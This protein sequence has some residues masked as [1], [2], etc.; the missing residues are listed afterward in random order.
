MTV[1]RA[2]KVKCSKERRFP[3]LLYPNSPLTVP[4]CVAP[5]PPEEENNKDNQEKS[6]EEHEPEKAVPPQQEQPE[7]QKHE[8]SNHDCV[9]SPRGTVYHRLKFVPASVP[10]M[11][12]LVEEIE[13]NEFYHI[14]QIVHQQLER[15][16][17]GLLFQKDGQLDALKM[18]VNRLRRANKELVLKNQHLKQLILTPPEA[19]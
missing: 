9:A 8:E 11:V 4:L 6:G 18:E 16:F 7:E 1:T 3:S 17:M 5:T 19:A 2:A 12:R 13:K 15:Q 10:E 14:T